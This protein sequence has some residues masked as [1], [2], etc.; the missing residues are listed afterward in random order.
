MISDADM[1][2]KARDI[3]TKI[4]EELE[5]PGQVKINMIRETRVFDYAR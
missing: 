3:A 1:I 2:L 5:Y 4:E